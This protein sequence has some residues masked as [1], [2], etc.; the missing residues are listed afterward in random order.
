MG[1]I[2]LPISLFWGK[3]RPFLKKSEK[4]GAEKGFVVMKSR[5]NYCLL[6]QGTVKP[7]DS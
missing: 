3:V 6:L 1:Q 5:I 7:T 2:V 4:K